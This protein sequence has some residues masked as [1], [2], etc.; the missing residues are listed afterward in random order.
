MLRYLPCEQTENKTY[1]FSFVVKTETEADVDLIDVLS[2]T[3]STDY[4]KTAGENGETVVTG[5]FKY[6]AGSN[7][8]AI[9]FMPAAKIEQA[10]KITVSDIVFT[11]ATEA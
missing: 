11:E 4:T 8:L 1:T 10:V 5:T 3:G 7:P 6:L 9:Q 2:V